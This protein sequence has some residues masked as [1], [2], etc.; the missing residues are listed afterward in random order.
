[1]KNTTQKN[2]AKAICSAIKQ[3]RSDTLMMRLGRYVYKNVNR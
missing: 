1:M 3:T 2:S